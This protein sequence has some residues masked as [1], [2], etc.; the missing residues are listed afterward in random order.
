MPGSIAG[1]TLVA[2]PSSTTTYTVIG[3]NNPTCQNTAFVTITVNTLPMVSINGI[4]SICANQ[5]TT[6]TGSGANGYT[7]F[8]NSMVGTN[9]V[10]APMSTTNYTVV[11]I[12][13]F[14]CN[15]SMLFTI[16]VNTTPNITID[17]PKTICNGTLVVASASGAAFYQWLPTNNINSIA[18]LSV[19]GI[20]VFTVVGTSNFGCKTT[21]T[22]QIGGKDCPTTQEKG[23]LKSI[24]S[25]INI[26]PNPAS[27]VIKIIT[28]E[29]LKSV[30]IYD[31]QGREIREYHQSYIDVSHLANGTYLLKIKNIND[32]ES[33]KK[34]VISK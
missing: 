25:S 2:N 12:N 16:T 11:G 23:V 14:G 13:S 6:I 15:N 30:I 18:Q 5:N 4:M 1:A 29:S 21:Q 22:I 9:Q 10:L 33:M 8:P 26:V 7:W 17:Y 19:S 31:M 20:D 27:H 32:V 28:E 3:Y 34:I 24:E